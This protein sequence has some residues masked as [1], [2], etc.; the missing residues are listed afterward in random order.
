M[1]LVTVRVVPRANRTSVGVEDRGIVVRVRAA[2][3]GGRAT[4]EA[5]RA[6]AEALGVPGS[7]LALRRGTR[8]RTKVF[9]VAG[10]GQKE[11]EM[12]LRAT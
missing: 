10:L 3:E 1:G 11:A 7:A 12:R 2:P 6:L 4:D 9:E 8:S 5:R